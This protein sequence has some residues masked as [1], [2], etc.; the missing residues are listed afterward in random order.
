MAASRTNAFLIPE[1]GEFLRHD[2]HQGWRADSSWARGQAWA[3]YGFTWAARYTQDE[4]FLDA[5][6]RAA[7]FYIARTAE[8]GIPPNDWEEPQPE[9]PFESSAAAAAASA[10]LQLAE[11]CGK[12]FRVLP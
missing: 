7:D 9:L 6:T 10:M 2:T 1:T 3:I 11:F 8:H 5:A 4:R 12:G